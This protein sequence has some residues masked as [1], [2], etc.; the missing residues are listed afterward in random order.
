MPNMISLRNHL[1][2]TTQGYAIKFNPNV[3]T[4]V[5][6]SAVP[7]AMGV[8]CVLTD[9]EAPQYFEA[10][11]RSRVEFVGDLRKSLILLAMHDMVKENDAKRFDGG[12][13]PKLEALKKE[14]GFEVYKDERMELYRGYMGAVQAGEQPS[15]HPKAKETY[16]VI[17]AETREDLITYAGAM[18][19]PKE[20]YIGLNTRELR[21][22]LLLKMTG[23][24]PG[25]A[26]G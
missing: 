15:L 23:I 4:Y 5:P 1:L 16:E 10:N 3:P 7:E 26:T 22:L 21:K 8:G 12:G 2:H 18:D 9:E 24:A 20:E 13:L 11:G 6:D 19:I 14:L 17:H 25:P